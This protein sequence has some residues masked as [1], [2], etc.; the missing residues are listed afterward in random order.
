MLPLFVGA[1]EGQQSSDL[2]PPDLLTRVAADGRY[3]KLHIAATMCSSQ[4]CG[5]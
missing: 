1:L 2:V 4:L 3:V 5:V